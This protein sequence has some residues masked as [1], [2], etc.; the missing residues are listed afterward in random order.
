[1]KLSIALSTVP[2]KHP[3]RVVR[4]ISDDIFENMSDDMKPLYANCNFNPGSPPK[5]YLRALLLG[6]AYSIEAESQLLDHINFNLLFRWFVGLPVEAEI[7]DEEDF[8]NRRRQLVGS[9]LAEEFCMRTLNHPRVRR[10][11][12]VD[13]PM[14]SS[15]KINIL[16][17][18]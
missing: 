2:T 5:L 18:F 17:A 9:G 10:V 3:L 7:W 15:Y 6:V 14:L 13:H 4:T 12:N 8:A 16:S 11:I 1:M